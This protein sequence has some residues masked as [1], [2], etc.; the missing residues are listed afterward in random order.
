MKLVPQCTNQKYSEMAYLI[1][2]LHLMPSE[3]WLM[4]L[5][6]SLHGSALLAA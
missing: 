1:H 6:C 3:G 5:L 2:H 4:E